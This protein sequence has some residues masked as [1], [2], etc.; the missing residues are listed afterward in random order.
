MG[1][2]QLGAEVTPKMGSVATPVVCHDTFDGDAALS[3]PGNAVAQDLDCGVFGLVF[4]GLDAGNA[5]VV[6][7]DG[8]Q[9][10]GSDQ[11]LAVGALGGT[12]AG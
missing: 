1:D 10:A 6:V 3:E 4:A 9:V 11:R 7:D 12:G 5:S 8:V 2:A